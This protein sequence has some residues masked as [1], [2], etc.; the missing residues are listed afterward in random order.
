MR[1]RHLRYNF[2]LF[3]VLALCCT[4]LFL[5]AQTITVTDESGHTLP[6]VEVY[7]EHLEFG[8][9]T[10]INGQVNINGVSS[11][12]TLY[13]R[14]LG[15]VETKINLQQLASDNYKVQLQLKDQLIDEVVVLGRKSVA[16]SEIPFQIK[17]VDIKDIQATHAQTSADALSQHGGVYVQKSQ[18]GG[19]SPVIRGFEA[20][21][22]LLVVDN[23]RLNNAIYRSGHLQNAITLDQAMLER[24][25]II[26][27]PNSLMYGSDALGGVVNFKT[28]NPKISPSATDKETNTNY[29]LRYS[30]ANHE[31]SAHIDHSMGS[32]KWGSITSLSVSDFG[33][34]RA[35]ANRDDRFPDFGLR[36]LIQSTDNNGQDI[37]VVNADPNRQV[38]TG[39]SQIDILQKVLFVPNLEHRIAANFQYS[40]S[41][42][43]PRYDNLNEYRDGQLRWAEWYYGPQTRFLGALDYRYLKSTKLYD[44]LIL[45]GSFQR[46][47]EDRIS[48]RFQRTNGVRQEE[49][50]HVYGLTLDLSKDIGS[51]QLWS[52]DYGLDIQYNNVNSAA[53]TTTVDMV[54]DISPLPL[55]RY[56]SD[57]N[58]LTNTGAY[59][60]LQ[61]RS[62]NEQFSYNGGMRYA[63]SSYFLRYSLDDA[64]DW[65]SNFYDGINGSNNALTWSVGG[66]WAA[67][68]SW[69]I[70]SMISTAFRSPNIDDLSKIR[71]NSSEI[72]FPNLD[73]KPERS[74]NAELTVAFNG[75]GIVDFSVT[76]FYTKL[77]DAI[78]RRPFTAP[79]GESTWS[80]QGEIL[81][82]VGNVNA[83]EGEIKGISVNAS[84]DLSSKLKW[85]GSINFTSGTEITANGENIPLPHIAP[86]YGKLGL[87]YET[88]AFAFKGIYRFNGAKPL[89]EYGGTVD[90]PDL[91]TPIGALSWSTFNL[92]GSYNISDKTSFS[93]AIENL[94]D[95]HYR[96]FASG[97][98]APGLN[99]IASFRGSF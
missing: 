79:D 72:T 90:N 94:F 65:P 91:A 89:S 66:T 21:R 69:Q 5:C 35:G 57:A 4:S 15:Y 20:N 55:S 9:T 8:E 98:S 30:S 80:T 83:Q 42:D 46:I 22:V 58:T 62:S 19:G 52:L 47:D 18:M 26:F 40:T 92:Y 84:G 74:S 11:N 43:V 6:G 1:G 28:K 81:N 29:Y 13:F 10:D 87:D 60:Y 39:Y 3:N 31:K 71:I 53:Q 56:A 36:P 41:T 32:E 14:Y 67:S 86:T 78:I 77:K 48:R 51:K 73:L 64:V 68:K 45:I 33:D 44:Q 96:P 27:G 99:L 24:M 34:L 61:G 54:P 49:D 7:S 12:T 93:L 23:I 37:T 25:E 82:V 76:G 97:V 59:V 88:G 38:G 63:N 95:L 75:G 16:Q 85:Y 2:Q 70:R 17:T 50:V